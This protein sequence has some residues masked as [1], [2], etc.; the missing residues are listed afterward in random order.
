MV[1]RIFKCDEPCM[2]NGQ[3]KVF[4]RHLVP[5][6]T[7]PDC[8]LVDVKSRDFGR[9]HVGAEGWKSEESFLISFSEWRDQQ[10][11]MLLMSCADWVQTDLGR[12]VLVRDAQVPWHAR[13]ALEVKD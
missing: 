5:V 8:F 3:N 6:P 10:E 2:W 11:A 13:L 1:G 4:F 9:L 7:Q 12:L